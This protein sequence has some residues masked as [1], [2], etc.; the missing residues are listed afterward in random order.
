MSRATVVVLTFAA[1]L[2]GCTSNGDGP[3]PAGSERAAALSAVLVQPDEG[4]ELID[5]DTSAEAAISTS[6]ALYDSTP[7]VVLADAADP[8]MQARAASV[9]VHLGAPLLLSSGSESDADAAV[10]KEIQRLSPRAVLTFGA[11]LPAGG[12][13][14]PDVVP[15]SMTPRQLA[16]QTGLSFAGTRTTGSAELAAQVARLQRGGAGPLLTVAAA[17]STSASRKPAGTLPK[18]Q[19]PPPAGRTLVVVPAGGASAVAA[20]ATARAA[21]ADVVT[22]PDG[23]LRGSGQFV[24]VVSSRKPAS[25]LA[26]GRGF[27]QPAAIEASWAAART[28]QQLPGGGQL[29][30]PGKRYVALYG[31]P[32]SAAL[33]VLGEQ[34]MQET[35]ARAKKVAA[36]YDPHS[37]LPVIP[38]LEIITT[39]ASASAG[40]DGNYSSESEV[41]DLTPW[42]DAAQRAGIYVV[43]DLQPGTTDFLTQAKIYETLLTRPNV[44]LALD[45][46]WR[47]KPG[48]RHMRQIGSVSAEEVNAVADW[49]ADLTARRQLP[50]KMLLLHQFKLSMLADRQAVD[51]SR[52]ELAMVIQMDG[53]GPT[54]VKFDTWNALRAGAQP[55][56]H[57]GWKNFYDEDSPTLT[58]GQ[59]MAVRPTPWFVSYQ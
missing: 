20:A 45:P 44:G 56:F 29:V 41:A 30:V 11:E 19:L 34:G 6:R 13:D 2:S 5:G 47:L 48:Q 14:G 52:P 10:R 1:L 46:E 25:V 50:Q 54:S 4:A 38:T 43:L 21:G 12:N 23:D 40:G 8:D 15:A 17:E 9:A 53:H 37:D 42:V 35:L 39:V 16:E 7:V 27:G 57:F 36:E 58:P 26:V 51:T 22:A 3:A 59:T 33:G 32:G 18:T 31:Y 28:G 55:G 49:L 24:T